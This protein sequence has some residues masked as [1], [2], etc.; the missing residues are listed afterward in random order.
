MA[1]TATARQK[2]M[3][4]TMKILGIQTTAVHFSAGF[5]RPNLFFEV[6]QKPTSTG[7][8]VCGMKSSYSD[9]V[10]VGETHREILTYIMA[11]GR[12]TQTGIVYCM[13]KKDAE[14]MSDFLRENNVN[15]L[16]YN[17]QMDFIFCLCSDP[18]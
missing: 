8:S 15:L 6:R 17:W 1:L 9:F 11:E 3:S 12:A 2:V 16:L 14:D 4:D 5:D 10:T 18:G 7:K 13:T